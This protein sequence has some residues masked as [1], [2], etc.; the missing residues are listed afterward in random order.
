VKFSIGVAL[1]AVAAV[2]V[3]L[4]IGSHH[5]RHDQLASG[6]EPPPL[7]GAG[8]VHRRCK[9][10]APEVQSYPYSTDPDSLTDVQFVSP[11]TGWVLGPDYLLTTSDGGSHWR[12]QLRSRRS[13][14]TA[15]DFINKS[16]G[17]VIGANDLLAT[18]NG[19]RTW[20]ALPQTCP[21]I[22]SLHFVNSHVGFA[23]TSGT[24]GPLGAVW[25]DHG[26][27]LL[28]SD[29]AGR[30]WRHLA[31][32][33]QPQSVC[34]YT[35][36]RGWVGAHGSI[37]STTDAGQHWT[38]SF[39]GSTPPKGFTAAVALQCT[40]PGG[41]WA[42]AIGPGAAMSQEPHLG[43]HST[44]STWTA[45]FAEQYFPHPGIASTTNS[46]SSDPSAFS[47][48][49]ATHAVFLDECTACGYGMETIGFVTGTRL[50]KTR[51]I[52]GI[53]MSVSASFTSPTDG[54]VIGVRVRYTT[55]AYRVIHTT[56]GGISW[57]TQYVMPTTRS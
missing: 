33:R 46:P 52:P 23:I 43:L 37:Y 3:L 50:T 45:L 30:T 25:G 17:W 18:T 26:A 39:T 31:S 44:S 13:R 6:P 14:W 29:D 35:P 36:R 42:E 9:L 7:V 40:G 4:G 5:A 24:P 12:V 10:D 11:S 22:R 53:N 41:G 19:G 47:A 32:P 57:H 28:T 34:F 20:R 16:T 38:L 27:A 8:L 56:D 54:W 15:L 1:V 48:I 51:N 55:F 2:A 49:N 21:A